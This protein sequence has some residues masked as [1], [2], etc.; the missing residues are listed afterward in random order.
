MDHGVLLDSYLSENGIFCAKS[1]L[2]YIY[3]HVQQIQ[4][5]GLNAHQKNG[6]TER[7]ICTVS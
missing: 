7:R 5:C 2:W 3:Q 6:V 1:F 4:Y